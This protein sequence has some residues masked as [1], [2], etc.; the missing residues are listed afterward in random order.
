MILF[1]EV[2][3][4]SNSIRHHWHDGTTYEQIAG[5]NFTWELLNNNRSLQSILGLLLQYLSNSVS[6]STSSIGIPMVL[7]ITIMWS[8]S[9]FQ[10]PRTWLSGILRVPDVD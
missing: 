8:V 1:S 7:L 5:S 2:W 6:N 10:W 9:T 4:M 3:T